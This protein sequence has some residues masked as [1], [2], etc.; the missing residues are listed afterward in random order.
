MDER[1]EE[2]EAVGERT[3]GFGSERKLDSQTLEILMPE[4]MAAL[5]VMSVQITCYMSSL[6]SKR[7]HQQSSVDQIGQIWSQQKSV[8]SFVVQQSIT[9]RDALLLRYF[10]IKSDIL[11]V[12]GT[13]PLT[14]FTGGEEIDFLEQNQGHIR[15]DHVTV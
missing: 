2:S 8:H 9:A 4:H 10:F 14:Q 6:N 15:F 5:K 13:N 11:M 7:S 12:S 3:E 1:G